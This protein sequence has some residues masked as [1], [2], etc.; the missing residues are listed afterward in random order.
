[1]RG[2]GINYRICWMNISEQQLNNLMVAVSV[3]LQPLVRG[4]PMTAVEWADQYY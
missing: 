4:V 3:A 1:M 2:Q